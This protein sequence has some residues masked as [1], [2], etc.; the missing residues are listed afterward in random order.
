MAVVSEI[1]PIFNVGEDPGKEGRTKSSPLGTMDTESGPAND[2]ASPLTDDHDADRRAATV[3]ESATSSANLGENPEGRTSDSAD[4]VG[5]GTGREDPTE[6]IEPREEK[7][8]QEVELGGEGT[9]TPSQAFEANLTGLG[10]VGKSSSMKKR[11]GRAELSRA[12]SASKVSRK[13]SKRSVSAASLSR[14]SGGGGAG[15]VAEPPAS[16][17]HLQVCNVRFVL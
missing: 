4:F 13:A 11:E 1:L 9:K 2:V 3:G 14:R 6:S 8:H 12:R 16:T 17:P 15:V 7:T 10:A 5:E